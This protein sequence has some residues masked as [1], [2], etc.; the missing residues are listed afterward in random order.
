MVILV[1]ITLQLHCLIQLGSSIKHVA[2]KL[3]LLFPIRSIP[4]LE[5]SPRLLIFKFV[6][7]LKPSQHKMEKSHSRKETRSETDCTS[8][9]SQSV[10][11]DNVEGHVN[12]QGTDN[13]RKK[14]T[15]FKQQRLLADVT[16]L[17]T[18]AMLW[19]HET[20]IVLELRGQKNSAA[21]S[22]PFCCQPIHA[23]ELA[24]NVHSNAGKI[25]VESPP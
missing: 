19:C 21:V 8:L 10:V 14:C 1:L 4:T 6:T 17:Q 9:R 22:Q 7:A 23:V 5:P 13:L 3:L 15:R 18:P 24:P 12:I 2:S 20:H 11:L 25:S 16:K